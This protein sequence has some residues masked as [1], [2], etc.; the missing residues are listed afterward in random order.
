ME[1]HELR[2]GHGVRLDDAASLA[3]GRRGDFSGWPMDQV[4]LTSPAMSQTENILVVPRRIF[5][6][7]GAFQGLSFDADRYIP[8][9]LDPRNNLFLPRPAAEEDPTHKQLIPY[10]VVRRGGTV[11]CYT[12]GKSGG[13][14]RL[15]AK[16][17]I[18]I[19]GH[20]NDGDAHAEHFDEAAYHRAI[21]RE[22]HEELDI[23]G[24]Y[25]Q[26]PVALLNDDSN[27]VGRVHLGIVHLVDVDSPEIRPREDAI[28]DLEF[29]DADGLEARRER[30]ENWSQICL[31][32]L[33]RLLV[34]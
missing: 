10:L 32:G 16:M 20:I 31:G 24:S 15:H 18:G 34:A 1:V 8:A 29:L 3:S 25:R 7:L 17:S 6:Q 23:P 26:R 13:E 12:R 2:G 21:E 4:Q 14:S 19:G 27:D 5:E 22:L 28:R 30:L 33:A 11:L 9:L